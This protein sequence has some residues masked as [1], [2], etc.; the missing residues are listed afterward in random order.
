MV[1]RTAREAVARGFFRSPN[2]IVWEDYEQGRLPANVTEQIAPWV[3][4][5]LRGAAPVLLPLKE[6]HATTWYAAAETPRGFR[7]LQEELKALLGAT[8]SDFEGQPTHLDPSI[9]CERALADCYGRQVIR[10]RIKPE[11][12][13]I[14]RRRL[15]RFASLR[16]EAPE[17]GDTIPRPTGRILADFDEALRQGNS[18]EADRCID[19]LERNGQLDAQNLLYLRI[20]TYEAR[21]LWQDVVDAA[22]RYGLL[23]ATR[24]P[25]RIGQAILRAIYTTEFA[26]YQ[27]SDDA[28]G[29]MEHFAARV[30]AWVQPLLV[31]RRVYDC[32]EADALF[33]MSAIA[34]DRSRAN[35]TAVLEDVPADAAHRPWLQ[36]L[37]DTLPKRDPEPDPEPSPI[38]DPLL[39][40]RIALSEGDLDRAWTL[41]RSL[42]PS[43]ASAN[44]VLRCAWDLD[45]LEAAELALQTFEALSSEAQERLERVNSI[46]TALEHLRALVVP[47]KTGVDSPSATSHSHIPQGWQS[48]AQAVQTDQKWLDAC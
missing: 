42:E 36:N 21:G 39:D 7:H 5:L 15:A 28:A 30:N 14:V 32:A 44:V 29:A 2:K 26:P 18:T 27:A 31:S 25:R 8:Y 6:Q 46:A 20:R 48:W 41:S 4:R 37:I 35:A 45:S 11:D 17:R 3:D 10:L 12:R 16:D 22:R 13:D 19:E 43:E 9:P 23:H 34:R 40:A 1:D 38:V 33:V 24:R 47:A